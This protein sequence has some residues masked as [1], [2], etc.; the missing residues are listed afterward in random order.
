L[1][2]NYEYI[3]CEYESLGSHCGE[4]CFFAVMRVGQQAAGHD[5]RTDIISET[6]INSA[7]EAEHWLQQFEMVSRTNWRVDKTYPDTCTKLIFK[8]LVVVVAFIQCCGHKTNQHNRCRCRRSLRAQAEA[9]M[10]AS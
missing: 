5:S 6:A 4:D 2:L 1:P 7:A 3:I 9:S 8:V 10:P